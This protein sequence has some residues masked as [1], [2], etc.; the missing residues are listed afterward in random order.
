MEIEKLIGKVLESLRQSKYLRQVHHTVRDDLPD[1]GVVTGAVERGRCHGAQTND[2]GHVRTP[3]QQV[4]GYR[5][6]RPQHLRNS[7]K[8]SI[9]IPN[10]IQ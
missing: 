5:D 1:P 10:F 6:W 7:I 4:V 9:P 3:I 8:N 2:L